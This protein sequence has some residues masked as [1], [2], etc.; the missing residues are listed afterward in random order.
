MSSHCFFRYLIIISVSCQSHPFQNCTQ[1]QAHSLALGLQLISTTSWSN[2]ERNGIQSCTLLVIAVEAWQIL[3]CC[4][5]NLPFTEPFLA[6]ND[7][8]R[9]W[10]HDSWHHNYT[11]W[12]KGSMTSSALHWPTIMYPSQML[13]QG[14][15]VS[16]CILKSW[17]TL[18]LLKGYSVLYNTIEIGSLWFTYQIRVFKTP[19]QCGQNQHLMFSYNILCQI[20]SALTPPKTLN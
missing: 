5:T 7:V 14:N 16:K 17:V 1:L 6:L 10:C 19:Q 18:N 4:Y 11:H 13:N 8:I 2:T 3:C 9:M 12:G 15:S 20:F